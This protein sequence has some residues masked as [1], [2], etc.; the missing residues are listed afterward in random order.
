MIMK[1]I[2]RLLLIPVLL[3]VVIAL[4]GIFGFRQLTVTY[5]NVNL[6]GITNDVRIVLLADL[7]EKEFGDHNETLIALIKDQRPDLIVIAGDLFSR[8]ASADEISAA[9]VFAARLTEIAPTYYSRGNHETAYVAE[10]G[11]AVFEQFAASGVTLLNDQYLDLSFN[12]SSFRLGGMDRYAYR[13]GDG[14]FIPEAEEFLTDYCDTPLP[15]VLLSHRPEAF[16]F[17]Q[18][19][20]QW[21]VDLILSG[22][23]H[24]G[25]VRFPWGGGL[26]API[27]GFF[28]RTVYGEYNFYNTKMIV[29]S[30][31]AGYKWVP[32]MF[33]P[34][35][36]C[37]V[38]LRK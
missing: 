6:E 17:K 22:H 37:V 24:G 32:R 15:T 19:C 7:H 31:L 33:N 5:Y 21:D 36:I 20:S 3:I 4:T 8:D 29:T 35:E 12:G 23:T 18:A 16:S 27:Q 10:H 26:V 38:T 34:P 25:L 28:P 2:V 30:G 11:E 13:G 9:C 14:T 1:R